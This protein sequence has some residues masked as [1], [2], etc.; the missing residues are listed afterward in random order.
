MV[1]EGQLGVIHWEKISFL[2]LDMAQELAVNSL[3]LRYQ[4][5]VTIYCRLIILINSMSA[6]LV[7]FLRSNS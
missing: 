7:F 2:Q 3:C 6:V 1:N 4:T 5:T